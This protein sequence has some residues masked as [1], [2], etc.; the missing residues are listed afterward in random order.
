MVVLDFKSNKIKQELNDLTEVINKSTA[1][2]TNNFSGKCVASNKTIAKLCGKIKDSTIDLSQTASG[3]CKLDAKVLTK[4]NENFKNDVKKSIIDHL[5]REVENKE[6]VWSK[7]IGFLTPTMN[8]GSTNTEKITNVTNR[9]VNEF[10]TDIKNTCKQNITAS[11]E[12]ELYTCDP[13]KITDFENVYLKAP[14]KA[15]AQ[16]LANC[17]MVAIKS[18]IA[19]NTTL[20]DIFSKLDEKYVNEET[21]IFGGAL[22][23]I[24]IAIIGFI[25]LLLVGGLILFLVMKSGDSS[26]KPKSDNT[27]SGDTADKTSK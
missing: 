21:S 16:G 17:A 26:D 4:I 14:Q 6:S 25:V 3:N 9:L 15:L 18:A 24:V 11:N 5:T 23:W 27:N 1:N 19:D 10:K 22:K 7:L 13:N 2:I 12:L 8:F 20:N